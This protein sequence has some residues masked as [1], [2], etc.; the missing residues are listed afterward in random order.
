MLTIVGVCMGAFMLTLRSWTSG[1]CFCFCFPVQVFAFA[2]D[3]VFVS[4]ITC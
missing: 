4:F 1:E 3:L 2:L